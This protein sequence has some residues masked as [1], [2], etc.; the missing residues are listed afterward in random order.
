MTELF[1]TGVYRVVD[2][3]KLNMTGI[4][5]TQAPYEGVIFVYGKVQFVEG[6]QHLNFQ[7]NIVKAP[8]SADI[9]ELNKDANL[10]K[11]MGD[12]LVELIQHQVEKDDAGTS[13]DNMDD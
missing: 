9:D 5:I 13:A 2:N 6:K 1:D 8:E 7:R 4:E 11:L 3:D 12:I 10:Q